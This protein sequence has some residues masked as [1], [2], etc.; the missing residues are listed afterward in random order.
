MIAGPRPR[1]VRDERRPA[2]VAILKRSVCV[3]TPASGHIGGLPAL[4][5]F[6]HVHPLSVRIERI[7]SVK[8]VVPYADFIVP[9]IDPTARQSFVATFSFTFPFALATL[10]RFFTL[11][12]PWS[13][14]SLS[15]LCRSASRPSS[16]ALCNPSALGFSRFRGQAGTGHDLIR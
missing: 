9:L 15:A 14:L 5:I 11:A 3:R 4:A 1:F 13:G 7:A 8:A 6:F 10:S 16:A 12:H 2:I